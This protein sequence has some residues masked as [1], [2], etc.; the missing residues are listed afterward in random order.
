[1]IKLIFLIIALS[2][3][4]A[5]NGNKYVKPSNAQSSCLKEIAPIEKELASTS[6]DNFKAAVNSKSDDDLISYELSS[7]RNQEKLCMMKAECFDKLKGVE[8]SSCLNNDIGNYE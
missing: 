6:F 1:M 3:C 7:R 8:F 4:N 5:E 2:A